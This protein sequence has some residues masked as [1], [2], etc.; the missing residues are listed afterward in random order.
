MVPVTSNGVLT[1]TFSNKYKEEIF[2]I[3]YSSGQPA[4]TNLILN[5]PPENG[6]VPKYQTLAGWKKDE[7]W[8]IRAK[9]LDI[10]V[11]QEA[12]ANLVSS[13]VK[14][15]A[16]HADAG[17]RMQEEGWKF[18]EEGGEITSQFAAIAAIKQGMEIEESAANLEKLL[19]QVQK[20][21]DPKIQNR[22]EKLL[23]KTRIKPNAE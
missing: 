5:I 3:W 21:D 1:H 18:F 11:R 14:M 15:L 22:L 17:R 12:E 6:K 8:D 4:L 9:D 13:R 19:T 7:E 23:S 20:F 10:Q 16:R 2:T